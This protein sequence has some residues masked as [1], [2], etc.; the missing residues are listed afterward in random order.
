MLSLW[1]IPVSGSWCSTT[2]LSVSLATDVTRRWASSWGCSY[3]TGSVAAIDSRCRPSGPTSVGEDLSGEFD[4][5]FD[6]V[7]SKHTR[8]ASL[9]RLAPGGTAIWLGLISDEPGIAATDLIRNGQ[10]IRGSFGYN[11]YDFAR[12]IQLPPTLDLSW[13]TQVPL[14]KGPVVFV[15][16][17]QG[18][19][20]IVKAVLNP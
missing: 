10:T 3:R 13:T 7:G 15:E 6:A 11:R 12:A 4:S 20:D 5:I 18:R 16:L 2:R 9:A 19:A 1:L 14:E 17:M 8:W